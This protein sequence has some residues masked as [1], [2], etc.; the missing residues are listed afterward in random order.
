MN[1]NVSLLLPLICEM[2]PAVLRMNCALL[3][4]REVVGLHQ[5]LS[6]FLA[7]RRSSDSELENWPKFVL[8]SNIKTWIL[9]YVEVLR[10]TKHFRLPGC[11]WSKWFPDNPLATCTPPSA[12]V[13]L[14]HTLPADAFRHSLSK[15]L[16]CQGLSAQTGPTF[17][18]S[19]QGT[20]EWLSAPVVRLSW[21]EP[22]ESW[23]S[24][25]KSG[26]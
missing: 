4:S 19:A 5:D 10:R 24:F 25:L 16:S 15:T 17:G 6:Q 2:Q 7:N 22:T 12:S 9:A 11:Q 21:Q 14:H 3:K 20:Q 26:K 8:P 1:I 18:I 23:C 13:P